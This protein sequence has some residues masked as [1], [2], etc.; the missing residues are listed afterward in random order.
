M[1]GRASLNV[2]VRYGNGISI[3]AV[4]SA[5][6]VAVT[7]SAR[8]LLFPPHNRFDSI[9]QAFERQ[10][11]PG[12]EIFQPMLTAF[13]EQANLDSQN[14]LFLPEYSEQPW[15]AFVGESVE[16]IRDGIELFVVA[17]RQLGEI[18]IMLISHGSQ[19]VLLRRF[20]WLIQSVDCA[21]SWLLP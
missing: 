15:F 14:I 5:F 11:D 2:N 16:T 9:G 6:T 20:S 17:G 4:S 7:T 1:L 13:S 10:W 21:T 3:S 19:G 12:K 18:L 8:Q